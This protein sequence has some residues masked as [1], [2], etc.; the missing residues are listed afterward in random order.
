[1]I[2]KFE[3]KYFLKTLIINLIV[4]VLLMIGSVL[5]EFLFLGWGASANAPNFNAD[6]ALIS[7]IL[8]IGFLA[9]KKRDNRINKEMIL[10]LLVIGTT[11][12][13]LKFG[14]RIYIKKTPYNNMYKKLPNSTLLKLCSSSQVRHGLISLS[15]EVGNISYI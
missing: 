12:L 15:F 7:Q 9:L 8:I 4:F 11:Y 1:M 5:F 3:F 2:D 14:D 10:T 6:V 13:I